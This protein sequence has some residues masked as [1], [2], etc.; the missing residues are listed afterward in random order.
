MKNR[1]ERAFDVVENL[2]RHQR[3]AGCKDYGSSSCADKHIS[4]ACAPEN[5][6][7]YPTQAEI[8]LF[9][10]LLDQETIKRIGL[11]S[12]I[13]YVV[14]KMEAEIQIASQVLERYGVTMEDIKES[15][16]MACKGTESAIRESAFYH[17]CK[18]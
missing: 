1:K 6:E 2:D 12:R 5:Y 17:W 7:Y 18:P 9:G 3:C 11:D 16:E 4:L 8:L 10:R 14:S 15:V 13:P